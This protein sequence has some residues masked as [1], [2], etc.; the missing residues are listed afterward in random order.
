M[1][2]KQ[3][4]SL[5]EIPNHSSRILSQDITGCSSS[6]CTGLIITLI[7]VGIKTDFFTKSLKYR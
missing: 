4:S 3:L 2:V 1:G 7:I 5:K 6:G